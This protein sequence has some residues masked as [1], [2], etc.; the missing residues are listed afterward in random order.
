M[1]GHISMS[2][3]GYSLIDK[4]EFGIVVYKRLLTGQYHTPA[5]LR[6]GFSNHVAQKPPGTALAAIS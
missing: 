4:T 5:A 3:P 6:L 1:P 2:G